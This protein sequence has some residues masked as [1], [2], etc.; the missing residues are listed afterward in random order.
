MDASHTPTLNY[1]FLFLDW[2][3]ALYE[4]LFKTNLFLINRNKSIVSYV[5]GVAAW[6]TKGTFMVM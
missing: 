3:I 4:T 6:G 2:M 1:P 5:L